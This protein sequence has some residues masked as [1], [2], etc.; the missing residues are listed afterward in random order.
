VNNDLAVRRYCGFCGVDLS[1]RR[2]SQWLGHVDDEDILRLKRVGG[3]RGRCR[4]AWCC[5]R[6]ISRGSLI[7]GQVA[8]H[9]LHIIIIRSSNN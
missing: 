6:S 5:R 8:S 9:K 4:G 7:S 2:G 1:R 3:Y